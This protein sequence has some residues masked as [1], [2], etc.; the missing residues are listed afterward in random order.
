MQF[1]VMLLCVSPPPLDLASLNISV[2]CGDICEIFAY[3]FKWSL[4]VDFG[5]TLAPLDLIS[6]NFS[7][8]MHA[9]TGVSTVFSVF[10]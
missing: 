9:E 7:A 3:I 1:T 4:L 8:A 6:V 5:E 10:V 2:V